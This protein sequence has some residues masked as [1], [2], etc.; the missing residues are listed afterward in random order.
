MFRGWYIPT[1]LIIIVTLRFLQVNVDGKSPKLLRIHF[2]DS[3]NIVTTFNAILNQTSLQS[4]NR[5][6]HIKIKLPRLSFCRIGL[7]SDHADIL[8]GLLHQNPKRLGRLSFGFRLGFLSGCF[9]QQSF[10]TWP[11]LPQWLHFLGS[12]QFSAKWPFFPQLKHVLSLTSGF[13]KGCFIWI[14]P[15]SPWTRVL[16]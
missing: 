3:T 2:T 5:G 13:C 8:P 9:S 16:V 10:A 1:V 14:D 11:F 4:L 15:M 7:N 12:G 6:S